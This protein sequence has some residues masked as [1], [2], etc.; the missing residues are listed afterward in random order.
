MALVTSGL[1]PDDSLIEFLSVDERIRRRRAI[2]EVPRQ[3]LD[4]VVAHGEHQAGRSLLVLVHR[5]DHQCGR[6][7]DRAER[8]EP[9]LVVVAGAKVE[10][11][12]ISEVTLEHRC[13]PCPPFVEGIDE[14]ATQPALGNRLQQLQAGRWGAGHRIELDDHLLSRLE[15]R[16]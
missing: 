15:R 6:V 3:I 13:R 14:L 5:A 1:Q 9:G 10:E 4:E 7:H 2:A 8:V 11:D 16:I 12:W